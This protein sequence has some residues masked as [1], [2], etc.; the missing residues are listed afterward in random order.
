WFRSDGV[1]VTAIGVPPRDRLM[2]NDWSVFHCIVCPPVPAA[3]MPAMWITG[4]CNCDES[5]PLPFV[6]MT[7]LLF[8]S[9]E[10]D[11]VTLPPVKL[12]LAWA[13]CVGS[14]NVATTVLMF[15]SMPASDGLPNSMSRPAGPPSTTGSRSV[16]VTV[17]VAD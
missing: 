15:G 1:Q 2:A 8:A 14:G 16:V 9:I 10:Y 6:V 13:G 5:I 4:D 12:P 7:M 17:S 11:D 3:A